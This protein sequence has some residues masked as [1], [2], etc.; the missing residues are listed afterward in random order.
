M[1]L[2]KRINDNVRA[3]LNA[4]LDKAEDPA[5]LLNQYLMDMGDDIVDAESSVARQLVVVHKFKSQYEEASELVAKRE[6]Q[7]MEALQKDREDLA[8]RALEDKTLHKAR[9]DDYKLQYENGYGTAEMLKSQLREMKDEYERL[10][11]KRDTLVARAQSAKAQKKVTGISASFG[12]DNS[13]RGF[14]RM[15]EKVMQME[16]EIQ[17]AAEMSAAGNILDKE[18]AALGGGE[19]IDRELAALKEKLKAKDQ[20]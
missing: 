13:R 19:D 4:L 16:A 18:L 12:K 8:R 7:A 20:I 1:S 10:K 2:F 3:N 11:A 6:T 15:E 14:D 17:V 5:K 9:A